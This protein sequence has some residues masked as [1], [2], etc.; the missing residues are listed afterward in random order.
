MIWDYFVGISLSIYILYFIFFKGRLKNTS[1]FLQYEQQ[2]F[3]SLELWIIFDKRVVHFFNSALPTDVSLWYIK[4]FFIGKTQSIVPFLLWLVPFLVKKLTHVI[5][6]SESVYNLILEKT[7]AVQ[8]VRQM[9]LLIHNWCETW[10]EVRTE[11]LISLSFR[12]A[13]AGDLLEMICQEIE[14]SDLGTEKLFDLSVDGPNISKSLWNQRDEALKKKVF[15]VRL[16]LFTCTLHVIHNEFRK[17]LN[18]YGHEAEELVFDFY[19][20]FRIVPCKREDFRSLE[21]DM[22]PHIHGSLLLRHI[23]AGWLTLNPV[24]ECAMIFQALKIIF[25]IFCPRRKNTNQLCQSTKVL[26]ELKVI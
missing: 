20:W 24:L 23:G 26:G 11:Y 6:T 22:G 18:A 10:E 21:K 12:R 17:G 2:F 4:D 16:S 14:D 3:C 5:K 19:Y 9:D 25:L 15:K 1:V 7:T 13:T 8:V